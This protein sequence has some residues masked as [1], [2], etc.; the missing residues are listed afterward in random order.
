MTD[1]QIAQLAK[2]SE[3]MTHV[4]EA[5]KDIK[6]SMA[7]LRRDFVSRSHHDN[8]IS[9]I[10]GRIQVLEDAAKKSPFDTLTK[11]FSAV[12]V[13]V[14]GLAALYLVAQWISRHG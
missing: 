10:K 9:T 5:L 6:S 7:E 2:V 8:E 11:F 3:G 4:L 13:I 14:G 1:D 12:S